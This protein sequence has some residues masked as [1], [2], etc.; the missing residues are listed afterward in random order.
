MKKL[1]VENLEKIQGGKFWGSGNYYDTTGCD[2]GEK[3]VCN[4]YYIFWIKVIKCWNEVS[5]EC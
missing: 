5:V 2:D 1:N 3:I 4:D